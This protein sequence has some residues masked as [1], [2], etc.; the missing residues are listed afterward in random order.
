MTAT[1]CEKDYQFEE[2]KLLFRD[3]VLVE[4]NVRRYLNFIT[5]T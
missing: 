3:I 5:I 2:T 1:K 4:V